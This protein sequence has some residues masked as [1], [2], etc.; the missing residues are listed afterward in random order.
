[1]KFLIVLISLVICLTPTTALAQNNSNL[2]ITKE[3]IQKLEQVN[4]RLKTID[5][6]ASQDII[7]GTQAQKI[8][9]DYLTELAEIVPPQINSPA[10]IARIINKQKSEQNIS[11]TLPIPILS[12]AQILAVF[13]SFLLAI[14]V[15]WLA[16]LYLV[17]SHHSRN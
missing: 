16:K 3:Q 6:L 9:Q 4:C 2:R 11:H 5:K 10:E 17:P 1:M 7:S 13:S 8:Q 12:F 15:C 14:A